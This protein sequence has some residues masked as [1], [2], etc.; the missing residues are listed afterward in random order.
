MKLYIYFYI[1]ESFDNMGDVRVHFPAKSCWELQKDDHGAAAKR[2][3]AEQKDWKGEGP[4]VRLPALLK[5]THMNTL[6]PMCYRSLDRAG[7]DVS[8]VSSHCAERSSPSP[9][10]SIVLYLLDRWEWYWSTHKWTHSFRVWVFFSFSSKNWLN[11]IM[12]SVGNTLTWQ[13]V[14]QTSMWGDRTWVVLRF[15]LFKQNLRT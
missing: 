5:L 11:E 9:P 7:L 1:F 6:H 8:P 2:R 14:E 13:I 15:L 12:S 10:G 4:K 3:L